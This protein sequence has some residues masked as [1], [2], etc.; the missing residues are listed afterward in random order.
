[1]KSPLADIIKIADIVTSRSSAYRFWMERITEEGW[2]EKMRRPPT[3]IDVASYAGV[4]KSSVSNV[5]QGKETVD[6]GIRARVLKAIDELGYRPN[7]GAR[8]MRQR[9]KV[10]G[11]VVDD[12]TNPFHAELATYIEA[13]AAKRMHSILLVVTGSLLEH[14][15]SRVKSLIEHRVAAMMFLSSPGKKALALIGPEIRKV[16]VGIRMDQELSI[17]VDDSAGTSLAVE[18][19]AALGHE[20]IGFVSAMLGNDPNVEAARFKG[21]KHGMQVAGLRIETS[22]L[23]REVGN[24]K[25]EPRPDYQP[26]LKQFLMRKNRPTALV[27]AL[28]RVAL[29]II[30]AA[31]ALGIG[32]P[33]SL[34]LVG[35]DDIAIAS[36]SRIALTTI[37]QPM[38]DLARMAVD[39]AID[40]P[41][42]DADGKPLTSVALPPRLVVRLS[43]TPVPTK[44]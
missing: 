19:L 2:F 40:G 22:H 37:A 31:D 43:T 26:I 14:Q 33:E 24:P 15:S 35:F 36:H 11:V 18:H 27:A 41:S 32:I 20:K 44:R 28:D 6:A 1:M 16:F 29:E 34:S 12:L 39:T 4:S 10:L 5:L 13:C 21:Y 17:A 3:I 38:K 23:L 42:G 7:A 30:S 25:N 9:S 8:Y